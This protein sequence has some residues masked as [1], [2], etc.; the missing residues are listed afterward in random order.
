[1]KKDQNYV[2]GIDFGTDSV[3]SLVV[4]TYDGEELAS[5]VFYFPRWVNGQYCNPAKNQFRQH[6]LDYI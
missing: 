3:R 6:P 4:D 5:D 1:M 2:L